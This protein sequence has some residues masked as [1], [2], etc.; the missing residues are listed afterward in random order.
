MLAPGIN[1]SP[2]QVKKQ[3]MSLLDTRYDRLDMSTTTMASCAS[4]GTASRCSR[5]R[6]QKV[7]DYLGT[8]GLSLVEAGVTGITGSKDDE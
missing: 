4:S 1:V 2:R 5:V 6:G 3:P 8:T 7:A